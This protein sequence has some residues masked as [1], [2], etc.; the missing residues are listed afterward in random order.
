M[1]GEL[2]RQGALMLALLLAAALAQSEGRPADAAPDPE[3]GQAVFE[4]RCSMC[5]ALDGPGQGPSL[6][7]V[8]GRKAAAVPDFAYSDALRA[9]GLTWTPQTL[10]RF[11]ADPR[12]LVPGTAMMA[13]VPEAPDRAA[14]V[15]FLA[16]QK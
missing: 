15:A 7:G 10:S 2:R 3:A 11:L 14:L 6:K 1:A 12:A 9:S 8:V 4:D 16:Q 13:Q 5:H